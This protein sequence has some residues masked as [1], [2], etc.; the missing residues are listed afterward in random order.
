ML[1]RSGSLSDD[2]ENHQVNPLW[3]WCMMEKYIFEPPKWRDCVLLQYNLA[4]VCAQPLSHVQRFATPGTA[5]HRGPLSMEFSRQEYWSELSFPSPGDLPDSGI[6]SASLAPSA[7]A[8]KFLTTVTPGKPKQSSLSWFN[9]FFFNIVVVQWT[10][11]PLPLLSK[12]CRNPTWRAREHVPLLILQKP[13]AM[14]QALRTIVF[15]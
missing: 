4:C 1:H 6:G 7:L 9:F 12:P 14:H 8:G 5:A 3:T 11:W 10:Q 13:N 2:D 15:P